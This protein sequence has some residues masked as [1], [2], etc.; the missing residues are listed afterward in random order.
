[1]LVCCILLCVML[2]NLVFEVANRIQ[3]GICV[4]LALYWVFDAKLPDFNW[5]TTMRV[6]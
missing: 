3:L 5:E 1:M 4:T 6:K 2:P